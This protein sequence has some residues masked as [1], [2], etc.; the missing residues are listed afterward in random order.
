[1][2][3]TPIALITLVDA[4]RQW[5]KS[6]FGLSLQE[7]ARNISFCTHTIRETDVFMVQDASQDDRFAGSPLVCGAANVRFYAG[8]PLITPDGHAL[9][10]M[11]VMDRVPR[12][13]TPDQVSALAAV[14]R[15][16][17]TQLELRRNLI[18][19]KEAVT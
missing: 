2:C 11:C 4:D 18:E 19:F 1:M 16:V 13:L 5:F 7:T 9:G 14:S 8:I 10:A 17:L 6:K 3:G 12:Q 15:L